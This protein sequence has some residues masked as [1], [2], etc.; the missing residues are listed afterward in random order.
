MSSPPPRQQ[1]RIVG[2][3]DPRAAR[4]QANLDELARQAAFNQI[5]ND[6][7]MGLDIPD[8]QDSQ[9]SFNLDSPDPQRRRRAPAPAAREPPPQAPAPAAA[10]PPAALSARGRAMWQGNDI[11]LNIVASLY[12]LQPGRQ[13]MIAAASNDQ[14]AITAIRQ[15]KIDPSRDLGHDNL[16]RAGKKFIIEKT[17]EELNDHPIFA[18]FL[19]PNSRMNAELLRQKIGEFQEIAVNSPEEDI[20]RSNFLI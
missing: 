10:A 15:F 8:S 9:D 2:L 5:R 12:L 13:E 11:K 16:K 7:N 18:Q 6:Q 3:N 20:D 14:I 1:R 19:L 17:C 4:A